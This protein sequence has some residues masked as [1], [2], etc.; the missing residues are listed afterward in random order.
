MDGVRACALCRRF[1]AAAAQG[2]PRAAPLAGRTVAVARDAAF[3]F[4]YPANLQTLAQLGARLVFSR[5]WRA[6]ACRLRRR[7]VA[8]GYPELHAERLAANQRCGG[9]LRTHVA[10][11]RAP[12]GRVRRHDGAGRSMALP[13]GRPALWGL[14]PGM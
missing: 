14:L 9:S 3:A 8:G 6:S 13:D 10:A 2:Q 7:L 1:R 4:I 12:V 11:G 5:R